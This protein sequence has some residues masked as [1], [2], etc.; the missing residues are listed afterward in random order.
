M[1][2]IKFRGKLIDTGEWVYGSLLQSEIDVNQIA[3]KCAIVGRFADTYDLWTREVDPKTIGQL[4]GLLDKN[5]KEIFEG[6]A[7]VRHG[8]EDIEK[9]II[10]WDEDSLSFEFDMSHFTKENWNRTPIINSQY[11]ILEIIGNIYETP[12]LLTP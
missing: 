8:Q 10:S 2:E 7:V 12:E 11:S 3:V 4:T 9:G 1:R 6:D 5:K